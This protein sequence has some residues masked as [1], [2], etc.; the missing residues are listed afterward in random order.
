MKRDEMERQVDQKQVASDF[1][2]LAESYEAEINS[3][4]AFAGQEHDFF[5][6]VKRDH[7]MRMARLKCGELSGLEVLDLGCGVGTYHAGLQNVFREL[8]GIDVSPQSI[9]RARTE[10]PF[11][12]YKAYE[13]GVLPYPANRFDLIFAI[14]VMH[15]VPPA[16]WVEFTNEIL[17]TLRP[18]GLALIFEHNPLNPATQ[19][20]VHSCEIDKDAVLL[21]PRN[22]RNI[23]R[24][25]GFKEVH[26]KSILSVLPLS[27]WLAKIDRGLGY[28][29]FG[30][31]YFL[32]ARKSNP[33]SAVASD[34]TK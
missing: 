12:H 13:G 28:L 4:I 26:T 23:F 34:A 31:Q 2:Q 32:E 21:W 9:E 8:H 24:S 14:C 27:K 7:L 33:Q 15:H 22:L 10:S 19:Y 29:P 6:R 1:D 20:I 30:A 3:A 25:A 18:G 5:I 17:R 11:V 16:N